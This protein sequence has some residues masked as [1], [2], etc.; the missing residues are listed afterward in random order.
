M[1]NVFDK[2]WETA[3]SVSLFVTVV[4]FVSVSVFVLV[5]VSVDPCDILNNFC[6]HVYAQK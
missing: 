4:V 3:V 6:F 2:S 5:S 1:S